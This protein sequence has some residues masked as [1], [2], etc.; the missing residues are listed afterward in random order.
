MAEA[1]AENTPYI[2]LARKYRPQLFSDLVGQEQIAASVSKQIVNDKVAQAY[3]FAGPRGIGKT[4]MARILAKSLNCLENGPSPHPCNACQQCVSITSGNSLDMIEI[5]GASNRGIDDIRDLQESV[6]Q[7][8]FSARKKVYIIDEVHML[9]KEAFNA[10][11]KTLEEPPPFV[12]FVLATTE[13]ERIPETIRSRC[14]V[15]HFRRISIDDLIKRLDHVANAEGIEMDPGE[16]HH[17]FEAIAFAVDGGMRDA[18]MALD[19]L[20]ALGD[21]SLALDE[22]T[23]F[24]G[25]V[26]HDQL[27]RVVEMLHTRDTKGLLQTVAELVDHGRD[28]ERF[29]RNLLGFLRDLMILKSDGG[30]Q[31]VNLSGEKLNRAKALLYQKD[32]SGRIVEVLT[33]AELMNYIQVFMG[34]EAEI[35]GAVQLRIHLEF[36][37]V[38]LAAIE[39]VTDIAA[40]LKNFDRIAG[41]G[42]GNAQPASPQQS[43]SQAQAPR[44]AQA[45]NNVTPEPPKPDTPDMFGA[46]KEAAT[47][48]DVQTA[49]SGPVDGNALWQGILA[50][51]TKLSK[52]MSVALDLCEFLGVAEGTLRLAIPKGHL[53]AHNLTDPAK[54]ASL[55]KLASQLA[56][57]P[58]AVQVKE[59]NRPTRAAHPQKGTLTPENESAPS[60]SQKVLHDSSKELPPDFIDPADIDP[61]EILLRQNPAARARKMFEDDP[62]FRE[63]V[64]MVKNFFEG[65]LTDTNGREI[66]V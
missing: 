27:I 42:G 21:G 38:K 51:R 56:A 61:N 62:G 5:D 14:Q 8:P 41:S 20:R 10:L 46:R 34:L 44:Q 48:D 17:I 1:T 52:G 3:I 37:F 58:I 7:N 9:T 2:G 15:F 64:L 59:G 16:R 33:Y 30:E 60:G 4:S 12:I 63:K 6:S 57:Q 32:D 18:M 47:P 54:R 45:K 66:P 23:R 65:K 35:K 50:N 55:E 11:L 26:E 40:L 49:P 25:V 24:L 53:A 36:A 22:V 13:L 29:I 39:P 31:L 19:Q 43:A 28:L